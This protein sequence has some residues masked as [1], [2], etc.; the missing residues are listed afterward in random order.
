MMAKNVLI[1]NISEPR[2]QATAATVNIHAGE[3][4]LSIDR[5]T[6]SEQ[7][8]ASGTLQ[9]LESQGL[10]IRTLEST[11]D[12]A[13]LT[14]T[15]GSSFRPRFRMPWSTCNAETSWQVHINPAVS[16]D[17]TAH[18]GGGNLKLDLDGMAVTRLSA[19]TG[20]GN[21][22]VTLP[23]SAANLG[24]T[25][26][27]GAGNVSIRMGA[28]TTGRNVVNATSGAGNVA[29]HLPQGIAARIHATTGLGKVI[30]D[31]QFLQ[32]EGHTY[33]SSEYERAADKVEIT[34]GSGAGNVSVDTL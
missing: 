18:S 22:E 14:L 2:N 32:I 6:G 15:G 29:V 11:N 20:G 5:L 3:G 30:M 28:G 25:V 4:N 8:L 7:L 13:T 21:I 34:A 9:Y 16:S 26:K 31:P 10:P 12:Q 17:I 23:G 1:E 27:T 24:V 19:E 33:Q